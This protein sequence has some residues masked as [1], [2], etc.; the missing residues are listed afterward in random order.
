[1]I[2]YPL[3]GCR[4]DVKMG[5]FIIENFLVNALDHSNTPTIYE[6][7]SF[8]LLLDVILVGH[9]KENQEEG[10]SMVGAGGC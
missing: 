5:V 1:M 3:S 2:I 10:Q 7:L 8:W 6:R 4:I 9:L